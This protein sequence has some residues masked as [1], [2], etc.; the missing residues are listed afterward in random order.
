MSR[1]SRYSCMYFPFRITE[2]VNKIL[3]MVVVIAEIS[4]VRFSLHASKPSKSF[5]LSHC[6]ILLLHTFYSVVTSLKSKELKYRR[7]NSPSDLRD[8]F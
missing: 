8:I 6:L 1:V 5:F 2:F 4:K 7:G 3:A